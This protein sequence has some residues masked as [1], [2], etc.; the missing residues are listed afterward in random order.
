M[1]FARSVVIGK[2]Y[3]PHAGHSYLIETAL[4]RSRH[5]TVIVC[6][7]P[8]D[9]ISGD[10]RGEWLREIHPKTEVLVI[11]DRYD[12]NDTAVWAAN[13]IRWLG[14]APDAAFTSE[15]YGDPYA[16]AMGCV[17]VAVDPERK[18]VPCSA[19]MIR[20]DPYAHWQLIAP[21]VRAWFAKRVCVLGAEST[22]TT[23]LARALAQHYSTACVPEHGRLYSEQK[24]ARGEVAWATEEFTA[25]AIEQARQEEAAA[26]SCNRVL[27]CDTNAFATRVWHRRYMGF[28][29]SSVVEIAARGRCHL[30]LLTGDEIP[31]VQD[32]LRD[33]EHLRHQM[34]GWFEEALRAQDV[35]WRL[36]R[37]SHETRVRHAV[38]LINE[39]FA[40]SA[41]LPPAL[42]QS[43]I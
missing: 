8:T 9:S 13:T 10:L 20:A 11:D 1:S 4:R 16:R 38:E 25:I 32:G 39:L 12:E 28:E 5:V 26:R 18:T 29:S 43:Q 31:F 3:P 7:K 23:T 34:H 42:P 14:G 35:A 2:F 22:G 41:W 40:G 19:T 6:G 33:G 24:A 27:I 21:P 36:A 15:P 30:Y 37:G 17:H